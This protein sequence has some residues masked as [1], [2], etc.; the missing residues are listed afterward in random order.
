MK[1]K[2]IVLLGVL[3]DTANLGVSALAYSTIYLVRHT[4]PTASIYVLG[5]R[6][7]NISSIKTESGKIIEIEHLPLRFC[8]N[9][10]VKNHALWIFLGIMFCRVFLPL[11]RRWVS[12]SSTLGKLLCSS[13]FADITAG[14]SFS[15]IYGMK[16]LTWL[17]ITKRLCQLTCK[18]FIML[19]QTYG[20]FQSRMSKVL[21]SRAL[22]ESDLIISRDRE[23]VD[24]VT[25]LIGDHANVHLCPDTAFILEPVRGQSIQI[26]TLETLKAEGKIL[27]GLNV[28]GLLY[29]GGYTGKNEFELKDDYKRLVKGIAENSL[30]WDPQAILVLVPHVV[31]N[32]GEWENDYVASRKLVEQL[33]PEEQRRVIV[34]EEPL[35]KQGDPRAIKWIIGKLDFFMGSRM[36]ATIAA[37]SQCVPTLGLAYSKK[38]LGVYETVGMSECV[39]D[40]RKLDRAEVLQQVDH[41]YTLRNELRRRL[42]DVIPKTKRQVME[43]LDE[44]QI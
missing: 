28:S 21:A 3:M 41:K 42:N 4:W 5:G 17:Y 2:E 37:L 6:I 14:D 9:I 33:A 11:R 25:S 35:S 7:S 30:A 15:D 36:H 39:V 24:V 32:S 31:P 12:K 38:F 8:P 10:F 26:N 43:L 19:P 1:K 16:R 22:Q 40:L 29:H 27:V 23:G 20:P 13:L 18:P 44:I 34:V